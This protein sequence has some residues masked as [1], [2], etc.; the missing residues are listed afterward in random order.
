MVFQQC[1]NVLFFWFFPSVFQIDLNLGQKSIGIDLILSEASNNNICATDNKSYPI[2]TDAWL[3]G[4]AI[5]ERKTAVLVSSA[6][7]ALSDATN[8]AYITHLLLLDL[9]IHALVYYFDQALC[10]AEQ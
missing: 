3:N 5:C 9:V 10:K 1:F 8:S 7:L 4:S 6:A 2:N